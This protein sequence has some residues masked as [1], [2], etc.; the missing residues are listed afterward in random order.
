M[1][2]ITWYRMV[3]CAVLAGCAGHQKNPDVAPASAAAPKDSPPAAVARPDSSAG[4]LA[5]PSGPLPILPPA[6]AFSRGWMPLK[7]TGVPDFLKTHPTYDGRGVLIAVLD[8]GI[9][10]GIPGLGLTTSGDRKIL[11]LRDFSAEGS[12]TLARVE[13]AGDSI[14]V[15]GRWLTGARRIAGLNVGGSIFAGVVRE[16]A[17][18]VAPAADINGNGE[19]DDTLPVVVCRASDGWV[20]FADT[21]GDGSLADEKPVHD[22]LVGRETFGWHGKGRPSPLTLAANFRGE[23]NAPELDLFFDGDAH[24]SHVTGIAAGHNLYAVKGFDG[25]APGAQILGLKIARNAEGGISTTGSMVSALRYAVG[26]AT[27]RHL[28][29]VVNM[30]YGVG[31]EAEG[32]ARIDR[33]I[34][35]VLA[36]N[37]SVVFTISAGNDGPALSTLGVPGSATLPITVGATY[38]ASFLPAPLPNHAIEPLADFSSRGGELSK[39][40]L[41]A[42]GIAFSTVP[43]WSTGEEQKGGTSMASPHVAGLA[44]LLVSGLVQE[45][46]IVEA[47]IIKQGLMVTAA[48]IPGQSYLDEGTGL[49]NVNRAWAWLMAG[50][51]PPEIKVAADGNG[52]TAALRWGGLASSSDTLQRF[53]LSAPALT[54]GKSFTLRSDATWLSAPAQVLVG[55]RP[56]SLTL[57][58]RA[59]SLKNPGVYIGTVTGWGADSLAGPVFRLVNSVVVPTPADLFP[60]APS[61]IAAGG[62]ARVIFRADSARPFALLIRDPAGGGQPITAYLHEPGGQPFRDGDANQTGPGDDGAV[63]VVDAADVVPGFYQATAVGSPYGTSQAAFSLTQ[64]PVAIHAMRNLAGVA[65]SLDNLT[66]NAVSVRTALVSIGAQRNVPTVGH[67]RT[68]RIPFIAPAWANHIGIDV[69][70]DPAQWPRFTDF[71][72]TLMDSAGHRLATQPVNYSLGRITLDRP[73]GAPAQP[74]VLMLSPGFADS[75]ADTR[76]TA[77]VSIR[78]YAD[79]N[80]TSVKNGPDAALTGGGSAH[81]L[82]DL[83]EAPAALGDGFSPLG[84]IVIQ[85]GQ[86]AW[87][88]EVYLPKPGGALAP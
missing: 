45:K 87:T 57:G 60:A 63:F 32:T 53:T 18:G 58:Y 50:H 41:V 76:W 71:G 81:L 66:P 17:W 35:S 88:R 20:L 12:V 24:G 48:P 19:A 82:L 38:P 34:D 49:V 30:S 14:K 69:R 33:M 1:S 65:V 3:L 44:A 83:P 40:D 79:S 11:D 7:S 39:P 36:A 55:A 75:A 56:V 62:Q 46:R 2:R 84:L 21:D 86:H 9:D 74:M 26:F 22:Y 6:D 64:S 5:T 16:S 25:V 31:N 13:P 27:A 67:A 72:M 51:Q 61:L 8:G 78:L 68:E 15:G 28:A 80:H 42:P 37:P 77:Q 4:A 59:A 10:A 23:K 85:E 47:R 29:L 52:Y 70:M 43:R 54:D 73:E